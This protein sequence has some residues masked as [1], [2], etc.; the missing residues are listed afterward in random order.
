MSYL[1]GIWYVLC[2]YHNL[3]H[4]DISAFSSSMFVIYGYVTKYHKLSGLNPHTSIISQYIWVKNLCT[5]WL[6]IPPSVSGSFTGC[7]PPLARAGVSRESWTGGGT[8]S[9]FTE[10]I[11][12]IQFLEGCLRASVPRW[13]LARSC[14]LFFG[15]WALPTWPLFQQSQQGRESASKREVRI[16]NTVESWKWH[17]VTFAVFYRSEKS[18]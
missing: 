2:H 15:R 11:G 5:G 16:L 17:P 18:Y 3:G 4:R 13:V 12:S 10:M 14:T 9:K 7:N 8:A 1:K 6:E